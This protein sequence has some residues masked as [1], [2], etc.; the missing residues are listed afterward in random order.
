MPRWSTSV[1]R[2]QARETSAQVVLIWKIIFFWQFF[3]MLMMVL[4]PCADSDKIWLPCYQNPNKKDLIG[5][6]GCQGPATTSGWPRK[7]WLGK[8]AERL[9][10]NSPEINQ[11][12][13]VDDDWLIFNPLHWMFGGSNSSTWLGIVLP[14]EDLDSL[15]WVKRCTCVSGC[16]N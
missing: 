2:W 14:V 7:D 9:I 11:E 16:L 10:R 12:N 6:R 15:N 4:I 3:S 8:D 5:S 13:M 1:A